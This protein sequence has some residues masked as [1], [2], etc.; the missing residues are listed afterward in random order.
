MPSG[1]RVT[2]LPAFAAI[3][4]LF[5]LSTPACSKK[6]RFLISIESPIGL[7]RLE[8]LAQQDPRIDALVFAAEDYVASAGLIRTPSRLEMLFARQKVVSV[9]KAF[10]LQCIDLVCVDF[11]DMSILVIATLSVFSSAEFKRTGFTF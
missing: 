3:A 4:F 9:A 8:E 1:A 11:K 5:L 2:P 7:L 6:V 10:H